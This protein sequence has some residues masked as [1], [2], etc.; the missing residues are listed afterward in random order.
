MPK[1]LGVTIEHDQP[2]GR[3]HVP[4]N[5]RSGVSGGD[6]RKYAWSSVYLTKDGGAPVKGHV[7]SKLSRGRLLCGVL[8][9][10]HDP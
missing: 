1:N 5:S 2:R 8:E 9:T 6:D 4:G 7:L 3:D 10:V